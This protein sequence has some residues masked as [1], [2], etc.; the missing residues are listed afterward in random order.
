[1]RY[2][3]ILSLVA[4]S[5]AAM[6]VLAATASADRATSPANT[7]YTSTITAKS[8]GAVTL[9]TVYQNPAESTICNKSNFEGAITADGPGKA[10]SVPLNIL[11][12]EECEDEVKILKKGTL[13]INDLGGGPNGTVTSTGLEL[14]MVLPTIFG[15]L[16]CIYTTN[17][18]DI[19]T[20]TGSK[21]T[22][23]TA[24]IHVDSELIPMTGGLSGALCNANKGAE[25][26]GNY[27]ITGPDYL[28][29]D[30]S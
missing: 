5:A 7:E 15:N 3:K 9:H 25:L 27:E 21:T 19:G 18:T 4:V 30:N 16:H 2:L 14:T 29:I 22:G 13:T 17:N 23:K 10:I 20:L 11:K 8:E 24:T 28:D 1:M 12:F 6:S 26:T